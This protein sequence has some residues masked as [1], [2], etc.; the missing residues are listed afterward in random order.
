LLSPNPTPIQEDGHGQKAKT[1]T[2]RQ[3]VKEFLMELDTKTYRPGAKNLGLYALGLKIIS[4][5]A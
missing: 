3:V 4:I 1:K 5:F 2:K